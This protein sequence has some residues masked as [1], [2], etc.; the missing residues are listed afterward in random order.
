[1]GDV[2][3]FEENRNMALTQRMRSARA[4]GHMPM[5]EVKTLQLPDDE[6][7]YVTEG[8]AATTTASPPLASH[9]TS[10]DSSLSYK[11][12]ITVI[13][14]AVIAAVVVIARMLIHR[15]TYQY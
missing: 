8:S 5:W 11:F 10:S 9:V 4:S 12:S 7:K 15:S 13:A 1:M 3:D 2:A 6:D 14:L